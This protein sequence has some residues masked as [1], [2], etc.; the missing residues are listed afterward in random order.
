MESF[1]NEAYYLFF[2]ALANSTRLA[3]IDVLKQ[4]PKNISGISAVLEQDEP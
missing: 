4:G 1:S 2:S 3:I